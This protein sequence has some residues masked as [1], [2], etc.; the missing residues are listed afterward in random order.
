[1]LAALTPNDHCVT[2][3]DENVEPID[4]D[5]VAKADIVGLTGMD[6]QGH[7]MLE[8]LRELKARG[9]FTVVGGPSV[10]VQEDYFDG[11][12]D[13]ISSA[14]PTRPGRSFLKNW[15]RDGICTG[16]RNRADRHEPRAGATVR[17]AEG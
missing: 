7:R 4:Y 14:K 6:V 3:I 1:M 8:I 10:T 11:L 12:A 17:P 5:R 15:P 13:V 16:T 9:V 2:I